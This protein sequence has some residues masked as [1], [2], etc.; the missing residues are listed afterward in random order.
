MSLFSQVNHFQVFLTLKG[1]HPLIWT[2]IFAFD[3]V[4][5]DWGEGWQPWG[6]EG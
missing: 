1:Y 4:S 2:E 3:F 5:W 6:G